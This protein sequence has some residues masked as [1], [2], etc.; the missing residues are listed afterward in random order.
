MHGPDLSVYHF[1]SPDR[2]WEVE[3]LWARR[4]RI[5]QQRLAEPFNLGL[6]RVA[7]DADIRSFAIQKGSPVFRELPDFIQNMTDGDAV[8]CQ[9]D[10]G[11]GRKSSPFIIVDVAKDGGD[12]RDLLQLFNH[13]SI[14]DVSGVENVIDA[15]EVS[16][17]GRIKQAMGVGNHS[18]TNGSA[19]VH[20]AMTG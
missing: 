6:M 10:H 3:S 5:E 12:R 7:K 1:Q 4:A 14:A 11:L 17:D 13:G 2:P 20:G 8:A 18:D 15:S 19:V 9:F 16:P